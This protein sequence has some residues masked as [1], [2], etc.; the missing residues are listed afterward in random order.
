MNRGQ[1]VLVVFMTIVIAVF[2]GQVPASA[3]PT[4][5]VTTTAPASPATP[6]PP[7]AANDYVKD[8]AAKLKSGSVY[9]DPDIRPTLSADQAV[10]LSQ[11]IQATHQQ[12][13]VAFLDEVKT[14]DNTPNVFIGDLFGA[15]GGQPA[16]PEIIGILSDQDKG[17]VFL[18]Q[19]DGLTDSQKQYLNDVT[20]KRWQQAHT[21]A[22]TLQYF[23]Q[24]VT[25][26]SAV[27]AGTYQPS[28]TT[29]VTPLPPTTAPAQGTVS[30]AAT[31]QDSNS[32]SG[33]AMLVYALAIGC[34]LC[35]IVGVVIFF[36]NKK[37][38]EERERLQ[39]PVRQGYPWN[40]RINR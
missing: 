16:R 36:R 13:Y 2:S 40:E 21:S 15:M 5:P 8:I 17:P 33:L 3:V 12:I 26:I 11:H 20:T 4:A 1:A 32:M 31:T 34:L 38:R 22:N 29:P 6:A 14:G 35:A 25:D 39:H 23:D 28:R 18:A 7:H 30:S 37:R 27:L 24:W 9:V 19:S 10:L